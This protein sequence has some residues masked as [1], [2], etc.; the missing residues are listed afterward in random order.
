[1]TQT[2]ITKWKWATWAAVA[3]TLLSLYPQL[4]MWTTR[5]REW[6]G[7]YAQIHGDEWFYSAYI[8]A[9]IDGRPRR[10]D[11]YTGRDDVPGNPQPESLFSIQFMPAYLIAT[12]ARLFGASSSTAFIVLGI[13]APVFS[14]LA[15]F[16]LIQNLTQDHRLAAAGPIVVLCFG[17]LAA[18]EGAVHLLSSSVQYAFLPFLRRYEPGAVFPLFFVFCTL[19]WKSLKA[20]RRNLAWACAAGL[21][22][23]ALIFSYFYLWTSAVAWLACVA[24]VWFIAYPKDFRKYSA[25]FV[26]ITLLAVGA[27]IPYALLLSRRSTTMD[28]GQKLTLSHAPD[29]L[30]VPELLGIGVIALITWSAIRGKI[31]WRAPET[32]FA[33]S[34]ALM[35]FAVFNQQVITGRSLQPFH[36]ESFIAN[37]VTLVG[38]FVTIVA[39]RR[40]RTF[41]D[42]TMSYRFAN[43]LVVFAIL[44]ACL[45]VVVIP[46]AFIKKDSQFI[47][48]VAA[49]GERLRELS[50]TDV[51]YETVRPDP[52]P[53][54]LATDNRVSMM[55]PTFAPQAIFWAPNFDLLNLSVGEGR[56]RF[57]QFLYYSGVDA[58]QFNNELNQP[59]G[60]IAAAAFGHERVLPDLAVHAAPITRDDIATEVG[61]YQSYLS[62]FTRAQAMNHPVSYVIVPINGNV[63]LSNL[64]QWYERDPGE[65][66]GDYRLYRVRLRL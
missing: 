48:G 41:Q 31:S 43:R 32:L 64:D 37:Y 54:V 26:T 55:L 3:M 58:E 18:G 51:A 1:M 42:S 28:T 30:R 38:A 12:P 56:E 47:D 21:V 34:F 8:Q 65:T 45:E 40:A 29:L 52:R 9:L 60:N 5:G 20:T 24:L 63:N 16:W 27:L 2:E 4:L 66:I 50:K 13:L 46:R 7:S 36:Y 44:W 10:N 53:L 25:C 35:P 11:P 33:A 57:Y 15:L 23:A 17:A 14:C 49:V 61:H 19:V 6:N 62:S 59:M 39:I 22:L